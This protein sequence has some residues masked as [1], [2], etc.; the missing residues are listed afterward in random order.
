MEVLSK[1]NDLVKIW[2]REISVKKVSFSSYLLLLVL[3]ITFYL[4][5]SSVIQTSRKVMLFNSYNIV[6]KIFLILLLF[7]NRL[8]HKLLN[9]LLIYII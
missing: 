8:A 3:K 6:S 2:I 5:F 9:K 7:F 1:V 4:S